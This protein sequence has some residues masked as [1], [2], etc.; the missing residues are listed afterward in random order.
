MG[1]ISQP[2]DSALSRPGWD[3]GLLGKVGTSVGDKAVVAGPMATAFCFSK[4][5]SVECAFNVIYLDFNVGLY[6]SEYVRNILSSIWV[7]QV[8]LSGTWT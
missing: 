7:G 4:G 2:V 1:Y 8:A 6:N 5:R 3:L